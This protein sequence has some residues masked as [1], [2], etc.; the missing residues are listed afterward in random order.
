MQKHLGLTLQIKLNSVE[1]INNITQ[2]I[3][4]AMSLLHRFQPILPRSSQLTICKTFISSQLDYADVIYDQAYNSSFHDKFESLQYNACLA[5]KRTIRETSS[6]KLCQEIRLEF[7]KSRLWFRK[8]CHFY[9]ILKQKSPYL[10]NL[11]PN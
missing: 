9:K 8:L 4:K 2:K 6:E 1:Y 10:F 3:I 11:I 7:L 5:I